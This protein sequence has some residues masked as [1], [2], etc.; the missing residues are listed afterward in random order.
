MTIIWCMVCELW[1]MTDSFLSF[2]TVFCPILSLYTCMYQKWHSY[3]IWFLRYHVWRTQF[4]CHFLRYYNFTHVCHEWQSYAVWYL[5]YAAWGTESFVIFDHFLHFY[6]PNNL[7]NQNLEKIKKQPRDITIL[8]ICTIS[9][10]HMI[11]G[12]WNM[13]HDRQNILSYLT[14]FTLLPL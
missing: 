10:N 4:F 14:F 12:S 7:K 2:W 5:R 13:E 6:P 9:D 11:Y 3:D 1:S 8:H